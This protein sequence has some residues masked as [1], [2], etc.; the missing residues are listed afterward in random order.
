MPAT[1]PLEPALAASS[2]LAALAAGDRISVTLRAGVVADAPAIHALVAANAVEGHLLPRQLAEI[3]RRAGRFVVATQGRD[4]V[5]VAELA[6]LS[7]S[8]AEVRSLV[9]RADAR[10]GG[11]GRR[12][13][14]EVA[15]CARVGGVDTLV[16]FTHGPGFFVRQGFSLV[17]HQ[18]LPEKIQADCHACA[19]FRSCGQHAVALSLTSRGRAGRPLAS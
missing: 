5:G 10:H 1:L 7:G 14:A 17:P 6:P 9:V 16:A 11:L 4:L 19:L 13:V 12:I 15:R 18:W 8:V 3:E 2:T